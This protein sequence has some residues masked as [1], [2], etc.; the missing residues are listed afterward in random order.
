MFKKFAKKEAHQ[1]RRGIKKGGARALRKLIELAR[2]AGG[3]RGI[4]RNLIRLIREPGIDET[5]ER[6]Q[7][8]ASKA[9]NGV[10]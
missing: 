6:L 5:G 4:E 9:A 8:M 2:R 10:K 1:I 3:I 7:R